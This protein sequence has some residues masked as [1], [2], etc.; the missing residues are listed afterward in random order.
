MNQI[1]S[2]VN[3]CEDCK[4]KNGNVFKGLTKEELENLS[5]KRGCVYYKKGDIIYHEGSYLNVVY[6]SIRCLYKMDVL[7]LPKLL[8]QILISIHILV[9]YHY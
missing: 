4:L 9:L 3:K 8:Y 7:L 2:A 6:V 1:N 5:V